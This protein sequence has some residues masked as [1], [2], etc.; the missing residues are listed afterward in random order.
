MSLE[1]EKIGERVPLAIKYMDESGDE[2]KHY[3]VYLVDV[4]YLFIW[5]Q[6]EPDPNTVW[7]VGVP[8]SKVVGLMEEPI[9]DLKKERAKLETT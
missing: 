6:V 3:N 4:D 8:W 7:N 2:P 5:L 1:E 9:E